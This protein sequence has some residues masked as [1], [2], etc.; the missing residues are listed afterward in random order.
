MYHPHA[1]PKTLDSAAFIGSG[2]ALVGCFENH[3]ACGIRH[4]APGVTH[5]RDEH[6]RRCCCHQPGRGVCQTSG[7][8]IVDAVTVSDGT[9]RHRI[10]SCVTVGDGTSVRCVG[11]VIQG[12]V[13]AV[14]GK[15]STV[16][17]GSTSTG[18]TVCAVTARIS[19]IRRVSS[20]HEQHHD[21]GASRSRAFE[22]ALRFGEL[23][24]NLSVQGFAALHQRRR[25]VLFQLGIAEQHVAEVRGEVRGNLVAAVSVENAEGYYVFGGI[26]VPRRD[27]PVLRVKKNVS[28]SRGK[29]KSSFSSAERG[30]WET[31][32]PPCAAAPR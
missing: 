31:P 7:Q 22:L 30:D 11:R 16:V 13:T 25:R 27:P 12:T 28:V 3:R 5:V 21:R 8:C 14:T 6:L 1:A 20:Q 17:T 4:D 2:R 9:L 23:L 18:S 15:T 29:S 10:V 24:A 32:L 26:R 19:P